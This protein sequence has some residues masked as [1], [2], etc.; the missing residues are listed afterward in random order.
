MHCSASLP[1]IKLRHCHEIRNILVSV[2]AYKLNLL[3]YISLFLLSAPVCLADLMSYDWFWFTLHISIPE[4]NL[5][6]FVFFCLCARHGLP[7]LPHNI[8]TPAARVRIRHWY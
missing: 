5:L 3:K 8:N 7:A 6:P 4:K 2:I 1:P